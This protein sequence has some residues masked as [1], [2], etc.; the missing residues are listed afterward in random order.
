VNKAEQDRACSDKAA[1]VALGAGV[2]VSEVHKPADM[3]RVCLHSRLADSAAAAMGDNLLDVVACCC[4]LMCLQVPSD[5]SIVLSVMQ[6]ERASQMAVS[7]SPPTL[8][9]DL[10]HSASTGAAQT[11]ACMCL[12]CVCAVEHWPT[13]AHCAFWVA[14]EHCPSNAQRL[15]S[16]APRALLA[17][18][19]SS[20]T[21][22]T[23]YLSGDNSPKSRAGCSCLH[24]SV[25]C[26]CCLLLF[27]LQA[28][29]VASC[30]YGP[31]AS[32]RLTAAAAQARTT[33]VTGPTAKTQEQMTPCLFLRHL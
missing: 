5:A 1:C 25:Y 11:R 10:P 9:T 22:L 2:A 31:A 17:Y 18:V 28:V 30:R 20:C 29:V 12:S 15:M 19:A 23:S 21:G 3:L 27:W 14:V 16:S 26:V 33:T 6:Q 32:T 4:C 7:V 8:S 13:C 24:P